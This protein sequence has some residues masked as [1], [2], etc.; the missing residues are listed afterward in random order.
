MTEQ[1]LRDLVREVVA[2]HATRSRLDPARG[3]F[4]EVP[5]ER[6]HASHMLLPLASGGDGDGVCL[7]EPTVR[8]SHCGYC[9]SYGH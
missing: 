3:P 6:R 4:V 5:L 7:I 8:C 1:E 2:K 9:L